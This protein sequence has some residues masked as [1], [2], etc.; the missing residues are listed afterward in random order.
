MPDELYREVVHA[1]CAVLKAA[2][3]WRKL[4]TAPV[5]TETIRDFVY[6]QDCLT[7]AIDRLIAAE[8]AYKEENGDD[9]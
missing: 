7:N 1:E 4:R 8:R 3:E 2:K 5:G 6:T 9:A